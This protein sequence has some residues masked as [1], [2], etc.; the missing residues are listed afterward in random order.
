M[1]HITGQSATGK[2]NHMNTI[3]ETTWNMSN[4]E[5]SVAIAVV[6]LAVMQVTGLMDKALDFLGKIDP[7][8]K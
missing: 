1:L 6:V 8:N 5:L 3:I 2:E 7:N 4:L